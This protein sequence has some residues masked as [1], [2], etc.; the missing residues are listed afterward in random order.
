MDYKIS[1]KSIGIQQNVMIR[2]IDPNSGD[3]I[4]EH[5]G[6]N[7]ATNSLLVGI[8]HYLTGHG[9]FAS[10]H[11]ASGSS[12]MVEYI[13]YIPQYISLG[14]MGLINQEEDS[15]GL[16][17]GIGVEIPDAS[18][19]EEYARLLELKDVAYQELLEAEAALSEECPYWPYNEFC[20]NCTQCSDRISAKK[21]S[22]EDAKHAYDDALKAVMEYSEERRF[23]DYMLQ[24]PGYGADGYD[25]N[26]NN[27]R[28]YFGLGPMF[29]HR[30]DKFSSV[31]CELISDSFPRAKISFRDVVPEIEAELPKTI[32]V[33]FSAMIS[34]GALKQFR[35]TD[36]DYI[37][38]TEA[39][40]WSTPDWSDSGENGLLAAYRIMPTDEKYWDMTIP[41]SRQKLKESIIRVGRNQIVQVIWKIQ[42]GSIDQF[43]SVEDLRKEYYDGLDESTA[44][45]NITKAKQRLKAFYDTYK[46]VEGLETILDQIDQFLNT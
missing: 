36:K 20:A 13:S 12:T 38:I 16:P 33:V 14:T 10:G 11:F 24:R 28:K 45:L 9:D 25:I 46:D 42:L 2:V 35:E 21:Q 41:E 4:S 3:V 15:L 43:A 37:F 26:E 27:N 19:D 18:H 40:L 22:Y 31:K 44:F 34:T 8:G 32:D 5:V 23:I 6:H 7:S 1:S 29:V 39:G 30:E 17:A